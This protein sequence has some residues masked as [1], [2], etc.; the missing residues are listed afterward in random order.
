MYVFGGPLHGMGGQKGDQVLFSVILCVCS[1]QAGSS[2]SW[3]SHFLCQARSQQASVTL[4]SLSASELGF[5]CVHWKHSMSCGCW[6]LS[7]GPHDCTARNFNF[8]AIISTPLLLHMFKTSVCCF[9][10]K[11]LGTALNRVEAFNKMTSRVSGISFQS[12]HFGVVY[13]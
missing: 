6:D 7:F 8:W 12:H 4:L 3:S 2:W 5:T 9:L 1:F 10:L 11:V 13:I